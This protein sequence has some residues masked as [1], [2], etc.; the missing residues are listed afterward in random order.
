MGKNGVW[1]G[2]GKNYPEMTQIFHTKGN[3]K[4]YLGKGQEGEG[5]R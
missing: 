4:E 1:P 3:K 5:G 2:G